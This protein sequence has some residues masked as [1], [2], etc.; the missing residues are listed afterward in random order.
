[1]SLENVLDTLINE[2][3]QAQKKH[4]EFMQQLDEAIS[5]FEL[6]LNQVRP[7][8]NGK[9]EENGKQP[10]TQEFGKVKI[11]DIIVVLKRA[12]TVLHI[13]E[14]S[15]RLGEERDQLVSKTSIAMLISHHMRKFKRKATIKQIEKSSFCIK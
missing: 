11:E 6:I 4:D 12:N 1:M 15:Q 10:E 13:S 3:E 5:K 7:E 14:I 9:K 2:R 8:I